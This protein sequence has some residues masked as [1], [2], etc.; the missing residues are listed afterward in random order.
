[1]IIRELITPDE[2]SLSFSKFSQHVSNYSI[3]DVRAS[4]EKMHV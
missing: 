3:K 2:M 4:E 1:M